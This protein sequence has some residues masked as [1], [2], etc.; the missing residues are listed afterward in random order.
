M[1]GRLLLSIVLFFSCVPTSH[2]LARES[3]VADWLDTTDDFR[4]GFVV[5]LIMG[6]HVFAVDDPDTAA[7]AI[8]FSYD[9]DNCLRR[10]GLTPQSVKSIIEGH[11]RNNSQEKNAELIPALLSSL[12]KICRP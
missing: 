9:V 6:L 2:T 11:F 4:A 10:K 8:Q 7:K 3:T 5:G 1:R 12:A